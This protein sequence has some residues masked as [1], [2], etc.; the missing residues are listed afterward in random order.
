MK[1][2]PRLP[3]MGMGVVE[4]WNQERPTGFTSQDPPALRGEHACRNKDSLGLSCQGLRY[5]NTVSFW[6]SSIK[7]GGP[8]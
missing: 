3:F 6:S 2:G 4:K 7:D 5:Q 1:Q 8:P